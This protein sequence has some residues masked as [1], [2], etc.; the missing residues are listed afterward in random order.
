VCDDARQNFVWLVDRESQEH[1]ATHGTCRRDE[2][3]EVEIPLARFL[4][5][6]KG[7]LVEARQEMNPRNIVSISVALA[8]GE[9]LQPAGEY[10]LGLEWIEA[11]NQRVSP[12]PG[13]PGQRGA[14]L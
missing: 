1:V 3:Q 4:L 13:R 7:R 14:P 5:T 9:D 8:G 2:W 6:W 10:A 12:G 11:R